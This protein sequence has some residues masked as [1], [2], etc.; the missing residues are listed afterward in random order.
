M[1][2]TYI[3]YQCISRDLAKSLN[4]KASEKI[5]ARET[6]Y[7]SDHIGDIKTVDSFVGNTR[8]FNFAMQAFG[9]DDMAYAKGFMKKILSGEPDANGQLLVDRIQDARFREFAKA[10]DFRTYGAR[11]TQRA[12]ACKA[13][14]EA[15]VRQKLES[16]AGEQDEGTRLA[17]YFKRQAGAINSAFGILADK[18][19]A[20]VVRTTLG[21]PPEMAMSNL[22]AQ[23]ALL[24]RKLDIS[25]FK[26]PEKLEKF[27]KRFTIMWDSKNDTSSAPMMS[28]FGGSEAGFDTGLLLKLQSLRLGG[29]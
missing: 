20:E 16:D 6:Q 18:A 1:S 2:S 14:I 28:L 13:P 3:N 5:I 26:D 23:A 22:D 15:Y 25:S 12:E 19:L 7:Y 8:I 4:N 29:R 11:T 9:L 17:L 10:F 27:I 24:S 21:L